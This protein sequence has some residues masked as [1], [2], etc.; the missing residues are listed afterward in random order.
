MQANPT[1][2]SADVSPDGRLLAT[3][4]SDGSG[5]LWD[6]ASGRPIGATLSGASGNPIGAAFI[7]QGKQ[8][9]VAYERGGV[10]WDVR[11][12]A[13]ARHACAVAGRTFT[14]NEWENTLPQHNYSPACVRR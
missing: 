2:L 4:S 9:A 10:A 12:H 8:L 3:T 13:W 11:P 7:R 6:L 14:R 5:R 1:L